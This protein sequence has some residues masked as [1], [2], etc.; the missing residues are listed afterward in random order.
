MGTTA[1]ELA[2]TIVDT[3]TELAARWHRA[4]EEAFTH[5]THGRQ[6][7]YVQAIGLLLGQ[8]PRTVRDALTK[9]EL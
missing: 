2:Q 7:G 6:E 3:V 8:T 5:H 4:S 9:G 1:P